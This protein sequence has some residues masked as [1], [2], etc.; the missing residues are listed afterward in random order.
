[1]LVR[2][3]LGLPIK[4]NDLVEYCKMGEA[5]KI[6]GINSDPVALLFMV[7]VSFF[8]RLYFC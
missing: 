8:L 6:K 7:K 2:L 3:I 5:K 1:M 4:N